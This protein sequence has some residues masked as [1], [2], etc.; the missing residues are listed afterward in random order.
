MPSA[1]HEVIATALQSCSKYYVIKYKY[2][3]KRCKYKY[4]Y[5]QTDRTDYNTLRRS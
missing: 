2:K 3:Y 1:G 4:Q 5:P